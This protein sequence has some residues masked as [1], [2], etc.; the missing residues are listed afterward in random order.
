MI[1]KLHLI[2]ALSIVGLAMFST[3]RAGVVDI[4]VDLTNVRFNGVEDS[5]L[6]T[7]LSVDLGAGFSSY[8]I[9]GVG[10]DLTLGAFSPSWLSEATIRIDNGDT[11]AA[12][13]YLAPSSTNSGGLE[14]LSS[15]VLDLVGLGLDWTQT[16]NTV[17]LHFFDSFDDGFSPQS[18][19]LDG[20]ITLRVVQVPEPGSIMLLGL[21]TAG[22]AVRRRR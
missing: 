4:F 19:I 21:A 3:A 11:S 12:Q 8:E 17:N 5:P 15:P 18:I 2:L 1:R 9:I 13:L 20:G 10:W 22:L 16:S 7:N 6:N 14:S